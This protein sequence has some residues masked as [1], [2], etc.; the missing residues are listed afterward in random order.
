MVYLV[1]LF[2]CV[3]SLFNTWWFVRK[4]QFW[5]ILCFTKTRGHSLGVAG[6]ES[7]YASS[8]LQLHAW[9]TMRQW[10]Q[11]P[12]QIGQCRSCMIRNGLH[13]WLDSVIRPLIRS[14]DVLIRTVYYRIMWAWESHS[15]M[16]WKIVRSILYAIGATTYWLL[17]KLIDS[18]PNSYV[19]WNHLQLKTK[20]RN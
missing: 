11:V 2:W 5:R 7:R 4:N 1:D 14:V 17:L 10:P 15:K 19:F 20:M 6:E 8:F 12:M 16:E 13:T 3:F 18:I 9:T